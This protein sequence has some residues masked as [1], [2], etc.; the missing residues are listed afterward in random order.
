ML[1]GGG[2]WAAGTGTA[3]GRPA[4]AAMWALVGLP[5]GR[6]CWAGRWAKLHTAESVDS[7]D[8][9]ESEGPC[10]VD[11]AGPR[12]HSPASPP[13]GGMHLLSQ[14][15]TWKNFK[16]SSF[17]FYTKE[18][19]SFLNTQIPLSPL[20]CPWSLCL[21]TAPPLQAHT[22]TLPHWPLL[23]LGHSA[24]VAGLLLVR[25]TAPGSQ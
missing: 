2:R 5:G 20:V 19:T 3:H 25:E 8:Q 14:K 22:P 23:P 11:R 13:L 1:L 17:E 12:A 16:D 15:G 21:W 10:L 7:Q 6:P 24:P 18:V 4:G 9:R